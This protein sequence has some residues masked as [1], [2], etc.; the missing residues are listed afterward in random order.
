MSFDDIAMIRV[1][2]SW[3]RSKVQ[4]FFKWTI[5]GHY[6]LY[7]RLF[8]TVDSKQMFNK[9]FAEDQIRTAD[10]WCRKQP[11]YQPIHNHCPK[12][13]PSHRE[14]SDVRSFI[15]AKLCSNFFCKVFLLFF[16][17]VIQNG[18]HINDW[19]IMRFYNVIHLTWNGYNDCYVPIK[20]L[21]R[22]W[23]LTLGIV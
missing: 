8:N 7:F 10:L 11:L 14:K 15:C 17:F 16:T 23:K 19:I 6:F 12:V 4:L 22:T 1:R 18:L 2:P 5:P 9:K 13:Q 21:R 3:G 20:A